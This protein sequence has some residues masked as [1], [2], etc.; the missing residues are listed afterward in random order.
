VNACDYELCYAGWGYTHPSQYNP[1]FVTGDPCGS[2]LWNTPEVV[3]LIDQY[4]SALD[5][6][7]QREA[8]DEMQRRFNDD[9]PYLPYMK[10]LGRVLVNNRVTGFDQNGLWMMWTPWQTGYTGAW[11]WGVKE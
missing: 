6:A 3:D 1:S 9:L 11:Y 4:R 7:G 8:L 10:L 5:E 2:S